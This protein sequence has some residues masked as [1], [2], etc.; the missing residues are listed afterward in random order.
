MNLFSFFS[1]NFYHNDRLAII[2]T[3]IEIPKP[4]PLIEL[5]TTDKHLFPRNYVDDIQDSVKSKVLEIIP[6]DEVR[7]WSKL[8]ERFADHIK[9]KINTHLP[10]R[11]KV[12]KVAEEYLDIEDIKTSFKS[13]DEFKN[14]NDYEIYEEKFKDFRH[15]QDN[16]SLKN[17]IDN[18][19]AYRNAIFHGGGLPERDNIFER[20]KDYFCL[21]IEQL[22]FKILNLDLVKFKSW[23]Y[24]NQ[25]SY[26]SNA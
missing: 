9:H 21:L 7:C 22:F 17:I 5:S 8:K 24:F 13:P 19:N 16:L 11:Q 4:T 15:F 2:F 14:P 20:Q 3:I 12:I 18:F 1:K 26:K 23:G 25:S 6:E 10:I